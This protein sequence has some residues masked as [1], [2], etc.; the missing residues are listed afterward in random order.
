MPRGGGRPGSGRKKIQDCKIK[1][2]LRV[3][4]VVRDIIRS[5]PNQSRYIED[6][7]IRDCR[8]NK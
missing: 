8:D 1:I 2:G 7:V 5:K 3:S 6:L 4:P